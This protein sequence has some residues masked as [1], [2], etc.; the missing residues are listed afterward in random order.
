VPTVRQVSRCQAIS[1]SSLVMRY[2]DVKLIGLG[3]DRPPAGTIT[4]GSSCLEPNSEKT[5]GEIMTRTYRRSGGL[6]VLVAGG[7]ALLTA[8][9]GGGS[10]A[11]QV[12]SLGNG[13]SAGS[14]SAATSG[15]S[16][17]PRGANCAARRPDAPE[18]RPG[19]AAE[20]LG[21][22]AGQRDPGFPRPHRGPGPHYGGRPWPEQRRHCRWLISSAGLNTEWPATRLRWGVR[23]D[24]PPLFGR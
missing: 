14:G 24:L 22:H 18:T 23:V 3:A 12:A 15:S 8:A 13:S 6:A 17:T 2:L 16:S 20:V 11:A 4:P 1:D 5:G 19:Q 10:G 7:V 9:C 21:V